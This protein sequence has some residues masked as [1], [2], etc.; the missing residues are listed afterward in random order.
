MAHVKVLH[1]AGEQELRGCGVLQG[2]KLL[3]VLA[4]VTSLCKQIN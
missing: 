3:G 2:L 1:G 4:L